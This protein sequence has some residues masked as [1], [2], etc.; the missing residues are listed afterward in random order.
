MSYSLFI[1]KL[2]VIIS[3]DNVGIFAANTLQEIEISI[4]FSLHVQRQIASKIIS[5]ESCAIYRSN[6]KIFQSSPKHPNLNLRQNIASKWQN[7]FCIPPTDEHQS[8][9]AN[10][11]RGNINGEASF[12]KPAWGNTIFTCSITYVI[13][14]IQRC[15]KWKTQLQRTKFEAIIVEIGRHFC[16]QLKRILNK[17]LFYK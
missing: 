9:K 10:Q 13:P 1:V 12:I 4:Q 8:T 17:T 3:L 6:W 7:W 16:T 2:K 14:L 15:S 5:T 11:D